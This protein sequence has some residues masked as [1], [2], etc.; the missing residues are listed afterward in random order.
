MNIGDTSSVVKDSYN[1]SV[2]IYEETIRA[3]DQAKKIDEENKT[4]AKSI[5]G[6]VKDYGAPFFIHAHNSI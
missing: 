3:S 5:L 2:N 4:K 1:T 6:F